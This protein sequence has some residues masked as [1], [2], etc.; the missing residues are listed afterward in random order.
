MKMKS[1]FFGFNAKLA[2]MLVAI[3][4]MF[5]SCY[6]KE[7]IDVPTPSTEDP[8]Y[9]I[10]GIVTEAGVGLADVKVASGNVNTSTGADGT[11][12]LKLD[13]NSGDKLNLVTFSKDKY[14]TA[15][16]GVFVKK[17]ANGETAI[18]E[19][20]A[21]MVKGNDADRK[22]VKYNIAGKISGIDG[23][24]I[25]NA[26]LYLAGYGECT[27]NTSGVFEA[28]NVIP[29]TYTAYATAKGYKDA[30]VTI[31][32]AEV[33]GE[34]GT[35][36]QVITTNVNILMVKA[37][38]VVEPVYYVQ[39]NVRNARGEAVKG[40]SVTLSTQVL[41][42]AS[43][44]KT[45]DDK[46]FY[47]FE[48]TAAEVATNLQATITVAKDGYITT[49]VSF[50][51]TKASGSTATVGITTDVTLPSVSENIPDEDPSIGGDAT[52]DIT[53]DI[54][55]NTTTEPAKPE[56]QTE[57]ATKEQVKNAVTEAM[58]KDAEKA[59]VKPEEVAEIIE[60]MK[61]EGKLADVD[62]IAV[63]KVETAKTITLVSTVE[64][65]SSGTSTETKTESD[66]IT[67]LP[68]T[69]IVYA[70]GVAKPV[71]LTRDITTEKTT[72]ATR[73]YNGEPTG[74]IFTTPM[75]VKFQAPV[76]IAETPDFALPVLY[77]QAN[78]SWKADGSNTATFDGKSFVAKIKHFSTFK[79]GF[80]GDVTASDSTE[81]DP[82]FLEKPCFTGAAP[83]LITVNVKYNGGTKYTDLTPSLAVSQQLSGMNQSTVLFVT[84]LFTKM[85]KLDNLNL[86]PQNK[87]SEKTASADMVI[88]AYA[89]VEGFNVTLKEVV[90]TY[91]I[92]VIKANGSPVEVT[93]Q[94]S[95]IVSVTVSPKYTINHGHGHGHGDD[96]NAG[97]GIIDFE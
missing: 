54:E 24:A 89:Q 5:A 55:K 53:E 76:E 6:E 7:D 66:Q 91:T 88:P 2:L 12:E 59:E 15:T 36:E 45:T 43:Y 47:Y 92:K 56:G 39:G 90:K 62:E 31:S 41:T 70:T 19:L 48:L 61:E 75:E 28:T 26:K 57:P 16:T 84:D 4:G 97:G 27:P 60:E 86:L 22:T 10:T 52:V 74:T 44:N 77:K 95:K 42:R 32:I 68:N 38:A 73:V 71:S 40:A 72:A 50:L 78:G 33:Q 65:N 8:V 14:K 21:A 79:F 9:K 49:P 37:D 46:G 35:G 96:L 18:Y 17:I 34:L 13:K 1:K 3:C 25:A 63:V 58:G 93:V 23:K 69:Q 20:N 82:T 83:Q 29:G 85:I 87:Y 81:L 11:Y 30:M 80:E 64:A 94:V 67:I 51:I